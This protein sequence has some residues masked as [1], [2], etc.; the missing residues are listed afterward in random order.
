MMTMGPDTNRT[1]AN[2][3]C[4]NGGKYS[5][6][7]GVSLDFSTPNQVFSTAASPIRFGPPKS[8]LRIARRSRRPR[9]A[10][11]CGTVL[12]IAI[13]LVILIDTR[14][15]IVR[16]APFAAP[17]YATAGLPV[18]LAAFNIRDVRSTILDDGTG[19]VLA[20]EG[21]IANIRGFAMPIPELY[22]A[23]RNSEG[24]EIYTWTTPPP[25]AKLAAGESVAFRARLAAPPE[26]AKEISVRFAATETKPLGNSAK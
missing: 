11:F 19:R 14:D 21:E 20:I 6:Q 23:L 8:P 10:P 2:K 3:T 26:A 12:V 7:Q 16:F 9:L 17:L 5:S 22:V 25:K 18:T 15:R 1:G 4:E 13:T 24:R